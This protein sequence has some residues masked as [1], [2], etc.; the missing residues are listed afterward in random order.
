[1]NAS[2][3]IKAI[4]EEARKGL[5]KVEDVEMEGVLTITVADEYLRDNPGE[6]VS[7]ARFRIWA[8]GD[9]LKEDV[10]FVDADDIPIRKHSYFLSPEQIVEVSDF[11]GVV[12]KIFP[13]GSAENVGL[14][15][16]CPLF[17]EYAFLHGS[18]SPSGI[19]ALLLPQVKGEKL[20]TH[21]IDALEDVQELG[22]GGYQFTIKGTAGHARIIASENKVSPAGL[23]VRAVEFWNDEAVLDR[24][25]EVSEALDEKPQPPF[26]N[27]IKVGVYRNGPESPSVT[28]EFKIVKAQ[29]NS[30]IADEIFEFDPASV[31]QIF[32]GANKVFIDVPR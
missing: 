28:W 7:R 24:K 9:K 3:L 18:I 30:G 1:M 10:V 31:E 29:V 17:L 15:N 11:N 12:A 22:G 19:P 26:G 16:F 20:W 4:S 8:K 27:A 21:T 14:F 5:A 13:L 6:K 2:L 32:D 23:R 25:I